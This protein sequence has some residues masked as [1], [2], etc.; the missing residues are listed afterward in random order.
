MITLTA[1]NNFAGRP[2]R[3]KGIKSG[4]TF[5]ING[6]GVLKPI[7]IFTHVT[8]EQP[9]YFCEYLEKR[10]VSYEKVYIGRGEPVP[11]RIDD[12]SGLVF[13]GSSVSVND[14]LP[15][16][17]EELALI[18]LATQA[19]VPILGICFGGQLISKVLGGE[20][21]SASMM[22]IGWHRIGLSE[23]AKDLFIKSD[24]LDDFCGFEWHGD[25]FSL[26]KGAFPLFSGDCIKNQ[27][28]LWKNCLALQFH[29]EIIKPMVYEWIE[30]YEH[31]LKKP[32][33]CIQ[34]KE[35]IL[36]NI[37]ECLAQQNIVANAIFNWW[38]EQVFLYR[39]VT[40]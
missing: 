21:C 32:S 38:L 24:L 7:R 10:G 29:P 18:K 36:E 1:K 31:C 9:G 25:T 8:C 23:H 27:G 15:W 37:D 17:F 16:V 12:V 14:P 2:L 11:K 26:P 4:F 20:V 40:T 19:H 22:Q 3:C 13:L 34:S 5:G 28:F 6:E 35:Q 30:R 33:E 39:E